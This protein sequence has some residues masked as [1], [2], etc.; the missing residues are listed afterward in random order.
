MW[1]DDGH[2][3]PA[4]GESFYVA[5]QVAV[6]PNHS[7]LLVAIIGQMLVGEK[8][9]IE[10]DLIHPG[11]WQVCFYLRFFLVLFT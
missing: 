7:R 2:A 9:K 10:V 11:L 1:A 4:S 6:S 3:Q 8:G 5:V